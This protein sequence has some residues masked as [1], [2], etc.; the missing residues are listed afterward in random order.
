M[1]FR[2]IVTFLTNSFVLPSKRMKIIIC[3]I[4]PTRLYENYIIVN[5]K[6]F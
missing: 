2:N 6:V 3:F 4:F 1:D 5:L